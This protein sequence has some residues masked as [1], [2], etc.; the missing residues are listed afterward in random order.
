MTRK[1]SLTY[2]DFGGRAESIRLTFLLGKVEFED[3]RIS[4]EEWGQLKQSGN[5]KFG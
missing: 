1:I 3:I 4:R 2:F 5:A